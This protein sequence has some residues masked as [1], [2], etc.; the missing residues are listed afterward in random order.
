MAK[1]FLVLIVVALFLLMAAFALALFRLQG[2][3]MEILP[4]YHFNPF[5]RAASWA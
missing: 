5:V 2:I 1:F 3:A 4:S